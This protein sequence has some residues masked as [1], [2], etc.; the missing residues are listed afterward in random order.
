LQSV[1][2]E[3]IAVHIYA[4]FWSSNLASL[5]LSI[6]IV[7]DVQVRRQKL[8]SAEEAK[9]LGELIFE[10]VLRGQ[11]KHRYSKNK[12]DFSFNRICDMHP[13]GGRVEGGLVVSV[14]SPLADE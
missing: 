10:D 2:F 7:K 4:S 14:V 11:R 1:G 6:G 9:L 5:R 3:F 13:V 8:S 12:M